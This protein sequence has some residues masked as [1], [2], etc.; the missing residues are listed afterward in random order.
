MSAI[1]LDNVTFAYNGRPV[2]A[3][4]S[5]RIARGERLALLGPNGSGK[6]TLLKL[7]SGIL[8]PSAGC[9]LLEGRSPAATPRRELARSIAMVPQDFAVP[10][11]FTAREIIEL[12]RTPHLTRWGSYSSLDR[13]FIDEA[14]EATGVQELSHRVFNELSGGERRRV[15]IAMALAQKSEILLLDEPT[16]QLDISRQG[17]VLNLIVEL[18]AAR[19][20]TVVAAMH[21]LNL[22]ARYFDRVVMLH[23]Q[24]IAADGAPADVLEP[25]F[26]ETVY[27][28]QLEVSTSRDGSSPVVL[29][30]PRSPAPEGKPW[31]PKRSSSV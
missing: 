27:G 31:Q 14:V 18:N 9:V 20:I 10:F 3:G 26:L 17:D 13:Q 29:P 21:D 24:S 2:L 15:M 7:M 4:L 28:G 1:Q 11:A 5:L 23:R 22:A 16:Q 6:S 19:G 8:T 30:I 12:G 25:D